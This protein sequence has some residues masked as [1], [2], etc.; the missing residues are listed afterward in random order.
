[1][2]GHTRSVRGLSTSRR[3]G[4]RERYDSPSRDDWGRGSV[5]V[6][7]SSGSLSFA[8]RAREEAA[9]DGSDPW[10]FVPEL[11]QKRR[12]DARRLHGLHT[13]RLGA[14]GLRS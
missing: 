7:A 4:A 10:G 11:L 6:E 3:A 14:T 1:V 2:T 9:R 13:R 8:S 12:G 5:T